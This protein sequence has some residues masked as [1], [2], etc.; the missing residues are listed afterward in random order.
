MAN[1]DWPYSLMDDPD[2][3]SEEAR[4]RNYVVVDYIFQELPPE[5]KKPEEIRYFA[6]LIYDEYIS[7]VVRGPELFLK[8]PLV[9]IGMLKEETYFRVSKEREH[10]E[11]FAKYRVA[12]NFPGMTW[13]Q[14]IKLTPDQTE[15]V[16]EIAK[17]AAHAKL[18]AETNAANKLKIPEGAFVTTP[19]GV[20]MPK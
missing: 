11:L 7:G 12:E 18:A 9:S 20:L 16:F 4:R 10:M 8:D 1:L 5:I 13:E 17:N 14:F 15:M 6:N 3:P 2:S 19:G